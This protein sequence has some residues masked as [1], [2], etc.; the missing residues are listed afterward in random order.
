MQ[1]TLGASLHI[2]TGF[3]ALSALRAVR[4]RGVSIALPTAN[5]TMPIDDDPSLDGRPLETLADVGFNLDAAESNTSV[6]LHRL[7]SFKPLSSENP[8]ELGCFSRAKAQNRKLSRTRVLQRNLPSSALIKVDPTLYFVCPE[9]IASEIAVDLSAYE[10]AQVI[11]EL[12]GTYTL[13]PLQGKSRPIR[14]LAGNTPELGPDCV[15]DIEPV[16]TL[17]RI[18]WY[19]DRFRTRG[20][21]ATL[22]RALQIALEGA[23]S[24]AE[25]KLALVMSLPAE[26]GGYGF[27]KPVLNKRLDV[28]TD[29]LNNV[30][31]VLYYLDAY[32]P[33][34]EADLEYESTAFHLDPLVASAL[35]AAREAGASPD[36]AIA[37]IRRELVNKADADRRRMRDLQYLGIQVIPVMAF[38]LR[39]V[40]RMDQVAL[41][42]ARRME[43]V[44]G[45][46][47]SAWREALDE[48][49][50]RDARQRL[51]D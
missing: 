47:L 40:N 49:A 30:G 1:L 17:S 32:W 3:S 10:L 9:L 41:A 12:C 29:E 19:A 46:D 18:R 24:P 6:D 22:R 50:Y 25:A 44:T 13:S 16:T 15:Y 34:A 31:G 42:L 38:D 7:G 35:T 51:L 14:K 5:H 27:P 39:N 21:T 37:R 20:G 26:E 23:A 8:L 28:P 48:R 45:R 36:P 43:D 33:E 4:F 11:M 2:L